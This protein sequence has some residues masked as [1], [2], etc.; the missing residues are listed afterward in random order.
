MC[1]VLLPSPFRL[2]VRPPGMAGSAGP[3][4]AR[5]G[6][7]WRCRVR[8]TFTSSL[9]RATMGSGVKVRSYK[10]VFPCY[11]K[12]HADSARKTCTESGWFRDNITAAEWTDYSGCDKTDDTIT[13]EHIRWNMDHIQ[14]YTFYSLNSL[15]CCF[16]RYHYF[17]N[18]R[19]YVKSS[20]CLGLDQIISKF[21]FRTVS[22]FTSLQNFGLQ[23]NVF[24]CLSAP[25]GVELLVESMLALGVISCLI[26]SHPS[27]LFILGTCAHTSIK[28]NYSR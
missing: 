13:M 1:F 16:W 4:P 15:K 20:W 28:Q 14:I 7:R 10:Y 9:T 21:R 8:S 27:G 23:N 3:T 12:F 17:F 24:H 19:M 6:S 18:I 2:C 22:F 11:F 25:L 5:R 26:K